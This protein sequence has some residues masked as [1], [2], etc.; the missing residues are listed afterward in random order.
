VR[1]IRDDD[2]SRVRTAAMVAIAIVAVLGALYFGREFFVPIA[3]AMVLN[4][5]FRPVVRGLQR[6]RVPAWAGALLVVLVLVGAIVAGVIALKTPLK[7]W[8][9]QVPQSFDAA[10][11]KLDRIREPARKVAEVANRIERN[12]H[13]ATT[14]PSTQPANAAAATT[15]PTT[16]AEPSEPR[17]VV[18]Q[19][20]G[21]LG[22]VLG[23]TTAIL[24]GTL[25]V[26]VLLLLILAGG[27]MF[28]DKLLKVV[29]DPEHRT[30]A[31]RI[32]HNANRAVL[33]WLVVAAMINTGQGV[34]VAAVMWWLGM[35]APL[36]WGALTIVMEFVPYLGATVM[37]VLLSIVA[38][39]SLDGI[40]HI[41]AVPGCYL[42]ITSI[43][44]N[45][46]SPLMFG[47]GLKLNPVAVLVGV[48]FW[49]FIWGTPGAFLAVPIMATLKVFA[50]NV[51]SLKGV[52]EFLGE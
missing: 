15:Q 21:M 46:V 14:Q 24:G 52:G 44:A 28:F 16:A 40:G 11:A 48:L 18:P 4:A 30:A 31:G 25:E 32:V 41:L 33:R 17:G 6:L 5:V 13:L 27:G 7:G 1:V 45:V 42:V 37:I 26:L 51:E 47:R 34:I 23:T 39:A 36:V 43:Q 49:W 50:D 3:F 29:R 12:T 19:P 8:I 38:L 2:D 22:S 10:Q 9:E 35:P 20:A